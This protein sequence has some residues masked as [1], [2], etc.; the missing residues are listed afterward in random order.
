MFSFFFTQ[1]PAFIL[2]AS[3]MS[4]PFLTCFLDSG[5][6]IPDLP[7]IDDEGKSVGIET[8]KVKKIATPAKWKRNNRAKPP[9][10]QSIGWDN[11]FG[12]CGC[13]KKCDKKM[14]VDMCKLYYKGYHE[15][16]LFQDK[17]ATLMSKMVARA[18]RPGKQDVEVARHARGRAPQSVAMEYYLFDDKQYEHQVRFMFLLFVVYCIY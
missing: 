4:T 14:S 6:I 15:L 1:V 10:A 18:T 8:V 13:A 16:T 12:P 11:E 9:R 2:F 17:F 5:K 3:P 7:E